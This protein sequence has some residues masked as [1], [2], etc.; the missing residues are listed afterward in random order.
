MVTLQVLHGPVNA[1][2]HAS[3]NPGPE[4]TPDSPAGMIARG[5]EG[6]KQELTQFRLLYTS[7][8]IQRSTGVEAGAHGAA[9]ASGLDNFQSSS[10]SSPHGHGAPA[11]WQVRDAACALSASAS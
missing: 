3:L 8:R 11:A 10:C 1:N 4:H 6:M 2:T 5:K 7:P 9:A